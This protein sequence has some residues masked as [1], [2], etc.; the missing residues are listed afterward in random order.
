MIKE[1]YPKVYTFSVDLPESPLKQINAY[2]IKG[3]D[4][5]VLVDTA[6]HHDLCQQQLLAGLNE[7]EVDMNHLEVILTH[8]HVDHT[9]LADYFANLGCPIYASDVDGIIINKNILEPDYQNF[10]DTCR[11]YGLDEH[12][13]D[14]AQS[15]NVLYRCKQALPL[16][17][18]NPGDTYQVDDFS[19]KVI[20]LIGHTPG[21]IGLYDKE[22]KLIFSGDT[23]LDPI[24]PNICYWTDQTPDILGSYLNTL[25]RLK[26][27]ELDLAFA[28]HR[29]VIKAPK[30]RLDQLQLH[31]QERLDEV[32]AA[33]EPGRDYSVKDVATQ[34]SWRIQAKGWQE[35]PP[36]Q[37][38][39]AAGETMAHL[40]HL[41]S[42]SILEMKEN[43]QV[44]YFRKIN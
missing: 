35:F 7:L 44:F 16:R 19:F 21:H 8:L 17:P 6:F 11:H 13:M 43:Q 28:A 14:W 42:L 29:Q 37:K 39:F 32:L 18:L 4:K 15:P 31:H 1:V 20:D 3:N 10:I 36:A 2:V 12:E 34:I 40:E 26:D 41:A 33:M 30:Q 22:K 5:T 25:T 27:L 23:I 38:W 9:G 24:S